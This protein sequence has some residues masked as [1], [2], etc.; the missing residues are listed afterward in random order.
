MNNEKHCCN[1]CANR[2]IT[3]RK[4]LTVMWNICAPKQAI[5]FQVWT[6][7]S[8]R[9]NDILPAVRN[10]RASGKK[11]LCYNILDSKMPI[12]YEKGSPE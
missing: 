7:T 2:K 12:H 4:M 6:K 10:C 9:S 1:N 8:T 5:S 11:E 3:R